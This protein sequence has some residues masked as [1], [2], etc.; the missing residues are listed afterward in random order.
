MTSL[1]SIFP[2]TIYG[3]F[4]NSSCLTVKVKT[5]DIE[6]TLFFIDTL[7]IDLGPI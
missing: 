2:Y 3:G 6:T 5:N 7:Q 1:V 4:Y